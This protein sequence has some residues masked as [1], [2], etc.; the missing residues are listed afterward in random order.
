MNKLN[1]ELKLMCKRNRDG[2]FATQH[3]RARHLRQTAKQLT[4]LGYKHMSASS[5]KPKHIAALLE[6][7]QSETSPLTH[8]PISI[9]TIKNRMS[10]L[11]WWAEKINKQNVIPRSNKELGIPDRCL[12]PK[13]NIAYS[14]A[15]KRIDTLPLHL[16][17]SLRLQEHF[18]LRREESA[19]IIPWLAIRHDYLAL[20][21]S[22]TKGGRE[23]SI[24]IVTDEQRQ[25]IKDLESYVGANGKASLIPAHMSYRQYLSHRQHHM[26]SIGIRRSHGLRHQYAQQRYI[27]LTKGLLLP[28][29]LGGPLVREMSE[30]EKQLD[31]S[32]R[33]IISNELGH[34]RIEITRTY[35]G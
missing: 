5:L 3:D 20:E 15:S 17:L 19:K 26:A 7:W 8:K 13:Q 12:V 1:Y 2:S 21:S 27:A 14:L 25:L 28:R 11:R 35:L 9:G 29:R 10:V 4:Q 30:R 32:A 24:P 22:W 23:R 31:R 18:G 33:L 16:Q 34:S 6:L